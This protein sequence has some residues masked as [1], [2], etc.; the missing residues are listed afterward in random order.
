MLKNIPQEALSLFGE[1]SAQ[2]FDLYYI[3][4]ADRP[5][6]HDKRKRLKELGFRLSRHSRTNEEMWSYDK[7]EALEYFKNLENEG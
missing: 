2:E 3:F 6:S 4:Y 7:P 1:C 5:L